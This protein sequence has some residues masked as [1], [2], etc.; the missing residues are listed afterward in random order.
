MAENKQLNQFIQR[1]DISK[2]PVLPHTLQALKEA[3]EKPSFSY[4][5]LNQIIKFDPACM[6][7]L[8]AYANQEMNK[9]SEQQISQVEHAAMFLG[10]ERLENYINNIK[11]LH[12]V[13]NLAVANKLMSLQYRGLHAAYQADNLARLLSSSAQD[14]IYIS[15]LLTPL[16]DLLC[17]YLEP[18][19]AQKVELFIH[20]NAMSPSEAQTRVFGFNY[21]ELALE[22]TEHWKIPNLFIERQQ[23]EELDDA[24]RAVTCMYL[25]EQVSSIAEKGW[26]HQSMYDYLEDCTNHVHFSAERIAGEMHR[27]AA[28]IGHESGEFY[29]IQNISAYLALEP[30]EVP[31]QQV[32][33]L[34]PEKTAAEAKPLQKPAK[35]E[36]K[37]AK[38]AE[39]TQEKIPSINLINTANDFPG[40]IRISM[41]A[42]YEPKVFAR[43]AFMMLNKDK[44]TLQTKSLRG[45]NI[46]F[47]TETRLTVKPVNLFTRLLEKPQAVFVNEAN[48]EKFSPLINQAMQDMLGSAEF[49]A[50]SVHVKGKPIGLFYMDNQT[51][52]TSTSNDELK[53]Q[54]MDMEAYHLMKKVCTLFD[55]QLAVISQ[56]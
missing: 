41:D 11:S 7:N 35:P 18:E 3:L 54:P 13:K 34:S 28:K 24:S 31:Y 16:S 1:S 39:I 19:K 33:D 12:S 23:M 2:L 48:Y 46:N 14:E 55:K 42:L 9:D 38:H 43:V 26:Y 56:G 25:A 22:L 4:R 6:I 32:L 53:P 44:T 40:L 20:Q 37:P 51:K 27:I 30:G 47:F 36:P 52:Q 8:L 17:W 10:M 15:A 21:H 50:K 45:P 29:S 49:I 5:H